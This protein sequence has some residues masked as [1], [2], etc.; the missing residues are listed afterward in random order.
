MRQN[1]SLAPPGPAEILPEIGQA[2]ILLAIVILAF[3]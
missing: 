1:M 3:L 2:L